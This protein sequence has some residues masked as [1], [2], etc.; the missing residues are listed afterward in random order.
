MPTLS[1]WRNGHLTLT[2]VLF[3]FFHIF[4]FFSAA[5][6]QVTLKPLDTHSHVTPT[7]STVFGLSVTGKKCSL[8][9]LSLSFPVSLSTAN[10]PQTLLIMASATTNRLCVHLRGQSVLY[11]SGCCKATGWRPVGLWGSSGIMWGKR[12][13]ERAMFRAFLFAL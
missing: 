2:A 8:F 4:S 12:E 3:T 11:S 10:L 9:N 6:L 5:G 13:K 1:F 7:C